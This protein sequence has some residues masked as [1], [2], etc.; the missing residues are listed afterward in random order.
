M[1][2]VQGYVGFET[3]KLGD[4]EYVE[5]TEVGLA[6]KVARGHSQRRL[7]GLEVVVNLRRLLQG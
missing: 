4:F 5:G 6:L 2:S 7:D 3:L 1:T